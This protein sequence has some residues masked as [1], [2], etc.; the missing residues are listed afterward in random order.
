MKTLLFTLEY[1]PFKGG[2]SKYYENLVKHWPEPNKIFILKNDKGS[3]INNWVWPKW[4]PALFKLKKEIEEKNINYVLVGQIL[5]LGTA[6]Y[7]VSKFKKIEYSIILHGLDF[8]LAYRGLR[9]RW[10][11]KK[12]LSGAKNIICGNSYT[13]KMVGDFLGD[14]NKIIVVNPGVEECA[15][16]LTDRQA[17]IKEEY[18]LKNK[19]VLLTVGRLV[20]RKGVDMVLASLPKALKQNP[21]LIYVVVGSGPEEKNIKNIIAKLKLEKNVLIIKNSTDEEKNSWYEICDIFIMPARNI[22]GDYEG[23]G[24]VY[25]EANLASKPVIAGKSGGVGDAVVDGE[26]GLLIDSENH[27]EIFMTILDL[28]KNENK[29]KKLGEQGK[30]RAIKNFNWEKQIKKIYNLIK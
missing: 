11:S 13:A 3:L 24:I 26:N 30:E 4:L 27:E 21:N 7:L 8:S 16:C 5:P 9:K 18:N 23:F 29:R 6:T 1:P 15:T 20:K 28:M 12:I 10:L 25:L 17:Q 2:V 22:K 19:F 14:K